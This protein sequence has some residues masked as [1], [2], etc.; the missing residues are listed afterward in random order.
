M[1]GTSTRRTRSG[2]MG[3]AVMAFTEEDIPALTTATGL[4][5]VEISTDATTV[6]GILAGLDKATITRVRE[7]VRVLRSFTTRE[8]RVL[9]ELHR[10]TEVSTLTLSHRTD[11][12]KGVRYREFPYD[13][14]FVFTR[15]GVDSYRWRRVW[16]PMVQ[17]SYL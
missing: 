14:D 12:K 2:V 10:T 7:L 15:V 16:S 4:L 8:I 17:K 1:A 13:K 9:D 5:G 11:K 6:A 3:S